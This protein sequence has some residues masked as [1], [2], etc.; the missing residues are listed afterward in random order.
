MCVETESAAAFKLILR[1]VRGQRYIRDR[2]IIVYHY[3][4]EKGGQRASTPQY[5]RRG[6]LAYPIF[7][8]LFESRVCNPVDSECYWSIDK[9][10]GFGPPYYFYLPTPLSIV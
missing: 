4:Q 8:Y 5:F 6:G 7:S 10:V 1:D 3:E 9:L 2:N